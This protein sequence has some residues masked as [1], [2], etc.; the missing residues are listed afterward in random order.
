MIRKLILPVLVLGVVPLV[1]PGEA[2][3]GPPGATREARSTESPAPS[4]TVFAAEQ[5]HPPGSGPS[6]WGRIPGR[7]DSVTATYRNTPTPLWHWI[8]VGP[9]EVI[10]LPFHVVVEGVHGSMVFLDDHRVFARIAQVLAPRELPYGI[11]LSGEAGGLSGFGAGLTFEHYAFFGER[12]RF[13]LGWKSTVRDKHRGILGMR[14]PQGRA[15][16]LEIGAGYRKRGNAR[17]FGLGPV[18]SEHDESFFTQEL[19]WAGFTYVLGL[20]RNL[21]VEGEALFSTIGN[22]G[23]REDDDP[24]LETRFAGDLPPGYGDRSDGV[25]LGLSLVH[26]DTDETGR[27][28]GGGLRRLQAAYF[29]SVDESGVAFW[30]YRAEFQHFLRLFLPRRVLAL[31]AY[32]A[33][34]E[35][36]GTDPIPFTRLLTNDDPDLLRGYRDFRWRDRGMTAVSLEYRWP[37]WAEQTANGVG[38]DAYLFTDVGQVFDE[39]HQITRDNLKGSYGLGLRLVT[40]RGFVGRLELARSREETVIRLSGDQIFQYSKGDL[41]HGRNPIPSR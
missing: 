10:R 20:P 1:L 12:N 40:L 7:S 23:P 39:F 16:V 2:R 32:L 37:L 28:E 14:F 34:L 11:L 4:A 29:R 5:A 38:L 24:S 36:E 3:S 17:Y 25:R 41:F 26:D 22:R 8:F 13:R 6:Y 31:R 21:A 27:P 35:K 15:N 19:S 9:Y 33:G 18:T 30:S